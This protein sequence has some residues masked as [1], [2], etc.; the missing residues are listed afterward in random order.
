MSL[1][2]GPR[3]LEQEYAKL[4]MGMSTLSAHMNQCE[5]EPEDES[6]VAFVAAM[7][8]F[9]TETAQ[10]RRA[11]RARYVSRV[12]YPPWFAR[13]RRSVRIVRH[14]HLPG[15]R[16]VTDGAQKCD[17]TSIG[18]GCASSVTLT[19]RSSHNLPSLHP[20]LLSLALSLSLPPLSPSYPDHGQPE[21]AQE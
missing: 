15:H 18:A 3:E 13:S 2:T 9:V 8:P 6:S 7:S 4:A 14:T 1:R 5:A 10:V 11:R 17:R 12:A 19:Y 20:S 16:S 21:E